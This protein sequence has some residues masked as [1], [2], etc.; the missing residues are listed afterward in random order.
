MEAKGG[1]GAN[2]G[3]QSVTRVLT[4]SAVGTIVE[5]YDFFIY[6]NAA[7]L[8]LAPLFFPQIDPVAGILASWATYA[9]GFLVRPVGGL[10]FGYLGDRVGRKPVMIAT[11]T[12]MGVATAAIGL[13]PT[14]DQIGIAAPIALLILRMLQGLGSGAEYAG[15]ILLAGEN[16]RGR[17][18]LFAAVPPASVDVAILVAAGVFSLVSFLPKDQF[19][20]WGWRV[21]FLL[22][23]VAV[24]IGYYI[25]RGV[26]ET[27]EFAKVQTQGKVARMPLLEVI[28]AQPRGVL[29]ALGIN[30][31]VTLGYVYQAWSLTYL[32]KT[33]GMPQSVALNALM[34]SAAVGVVG[35]LLWGKLSDIVGRRP[36]MIFG[37][38]FT[39]AFAYPFF[40]MMDGKDPLMIYIAM[41][42][43]LVVGHRA[44]YAVQSSYYVDLF[45]PQYRY[46]GIAL[47]REPTL[48]FISGP[49]PLVA[50]YLVASVGGAWWPIALI[51][52]GLSA[53]TF[54]ALMFAP[55]AERERDRQAA[56]DQ[57]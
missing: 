33:L 3:A 49:L 2:A 57:S 26:M 41:T 15:A 28:R 32:T 7:G 10:L 6:G 42:L 44:V 5:W 19:M 18:G 4:A 43:G 45:R 14:Y 8:V 21:P 47:A 48:A 39:I 17:R 55:A 34:I 51:M 30:V 20:A 16:T 24:G 36:V 46:S 9:L 1:S 40:W 27:P 23:T 13:L 29:V 11:L 54:V 31:I 37:S 25:R 38:V 12:L 35:S 53:V 50:T 22:A 56:A 52:I